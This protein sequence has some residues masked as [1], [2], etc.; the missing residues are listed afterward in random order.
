M[1][2]EANNASLPSK[3]LYFPHFAVKKCNVTFGFVLLHLMFKVVNV[4]SKG[5]TC[6]FTTM[7][8]IASFVDKR[9]VQS[10]GLLPMPLN[11]FYMKYVLESC[12][13]SRK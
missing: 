8:Q 13:L 12:V 4:A 3:Y 7:K 5:S 6:G 9:R 11:H 1:F 2:D 10:F